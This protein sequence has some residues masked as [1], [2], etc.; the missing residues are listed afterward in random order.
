MRV[1]L[2]E[3]DPI[4]VWR[5]KSLVRVGYLTVE[6]FLLASASDGGLGGGGATS[7]A[8]VAAGILL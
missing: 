3:E 4:F 7:G 8:P 5:L 2:S 6:A 1:A